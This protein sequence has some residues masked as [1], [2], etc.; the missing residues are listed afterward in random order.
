[1]REQQEIVKRE[2]FHLFE[3][4][5][6]ILEGDICPGR[7]AEAFL[8]KTK[9]PSTCEVLQ[10]TAAMD[11]F[12]DLDRDAVHV[13]VTVELPPSLKGFHMLRLYTTDGER[14]KEWFSIPAKTLEERRGRPQYFLEEESVQGE[15]VRIRGWVIADK[16]VGIRVNDAAGKEIP[17]VMQRVPRPDVEQMFPEGGQDTGRRIGFYLELSKPAGRTA[18]LEFSAGAAQTVYTVKLD[19]A[20]ILARKVNKYAKKGMQALRTGGFG[21]LAGKVQ[22]KLYERRIREIPYEE[23]LPRHLPGNRELERQ[24]REWD[25]LAVRPL[26]SIVVPAYRTPAAY[27]D[28]LI[29]SVVGQ[30][31][32]NWEMVIS[33]GSGPD[34]PIQERLREWEK[35]DSRIRALRP[36]KQLRISENTNAAIMEARGEYLVFADHDDLLTPNALYE[37]AAAISDGSRQKDLPPECTAGCRRAKDGGSSSAGPYRILYSDEDKVT[38]DGHKF[39]QPHFKPDFNEH[40]LCTVNYICHLLVMERSLVLKAGLLRPEY[41]GAQ[42]HDLL[43]RAVEMVP[44]DE[45][46]H[47]PKIL[48]HWRAHEA[49]TAQDPD[50]KNYAFDAG[51]RAIGEHYRRCGKTARVVPGEYAGLYRTLWQRERDPLVSILIPGK[52]HTADLEKCLRSIEKQKYRNYEIV[53]IENNS[54]DPETFRYY[55]ELKT[56]YPEQMPDRTDPGSARIPL[57]VVRWEGSF[58][59]SAIN[60]FGAKHARGE[61]LLLLNNDTQMIREDCLEELLGY[62]MEPETGAV[63]ARLYYEDDTV[64]HAGVV[65]GFGGIAGHC[66]V[67]QPRGTT[68]YMHRIIC[69]QEYSA[70]TAACVMV[71]REAFDA[72]GGMREELAVAFNDIDLCLKLRRAGYLVV[73]NPYA[74]LYHFESKSRGLED[75]P[76]KVARFQEEIAKFER[77][78]PE[79][80]KRG[81][82]YYN[83]N[84]TLESQDFSR[85]RL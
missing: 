79:I 80:L 50:S 43:L 58:N 48:Y 25:K 46:F 53:V 23:W 29:G 16:E 39:F 13:S 33:D 72:V 73:Y 6:Y 70:V 54:T 85:R 9:L 15:T 36:Q 24:R 45:I 1:M 76:E 20:G 10:S 34:S 38:M 59:F 56:R 44:A 40:L 60:N 21:G 84:L 57:R 71:K 65:I 8:D 4:R 49:S 51:I 32:G 41:D 28:Q 62:C 5:L 22:G 14:R 2:R 7:K 26:F 19:P 81:D 69:A 64:Q 3:S 83:P 68:G 74:E 66:F 17:A 52:D 78:W 30:T 35:K 18:A 37:M 31:Y 27:L 42:D 47:V 67:M 77:H 11:R 63:G 82:P 12:R 75:N 55:E 61:Y